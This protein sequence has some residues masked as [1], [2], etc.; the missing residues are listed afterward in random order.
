MYQN[1]FE[2]RTEPYLMVTTE[3]IAARDPDIMLSLTRTATE[4]KAS[5]EWDSTRAVRNGAIVDKKG[6]DWDAI[7]RQSPRLIEGIESLIEAA[8]NALQHRLVE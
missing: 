6:L 2:D 4:I 1:I 7:T 8:N 3:S 5:S